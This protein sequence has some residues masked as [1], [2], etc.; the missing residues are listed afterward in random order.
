MFEDHFLVKD[1]V[2]HGLHAHAMAE[3]CPENSFG[4]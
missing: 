3:I 1:T 2:R 4:V